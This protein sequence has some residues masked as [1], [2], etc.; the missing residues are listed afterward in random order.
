MTIVPDDLL[1]GTSTSGNVRRARQLIWILR[2]TKEWFYFGAS[3]VSPIRTG[4]GN[5]TDCHW[6]LDFANFDEGWSFAPSPILPTP[7]PRHTAPL[8]TVLDISPR[9]MRLTSIYISNASALCGKHPLFF[10]ALDLFIGRRNFLKD[11]P[12][13]ETSA[14]LLSINTSHFDSA[15]QCPPSVYFIFNLGV[16]LQSLSPS[17]TA[18]HFQLYNFDILWY[19]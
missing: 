16:F 2:Q 6:L 13:R 10:Y 9:T 8:R 4:V 5:N 7:V 1:I 17:F 12:L 15:C 14:H 11:F 19:L 3:F 18:Y